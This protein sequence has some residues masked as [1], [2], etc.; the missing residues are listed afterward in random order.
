M[1]TTV[2]IVEILLDTGADP[3]ARDWYGDEPL[4]DVAWSD[5]P[6]V[7][8]AL[9]EAGADLEAR[10]EKD[11][12]PLHVAAGYSDIPAIVTALL[13]AGADLE[14]RDERGWT[15][16]H[17]AAAYNEVPSVVETL[18]HA[19]AGVEAKSYEGATPLLVAA[20]KSATPDVITTLLN[21]GANPTARTSYGITPWVFAQNNEALQGTEVLDWLDPDA[22]GPLHGSIWFSQDDDGAYAWGIAWSFDSSAGAQSEA[23]GQCREYGGTRCAEAG[24]FQEACGALAIGDDNGYGT[25]WGATETEAK[26]DALAQCRVSND[27]CRIEVARCAQSEEAGGKGRRQEEDTAAARAPEEVK[28]AAVVPAPKCDDGVYEYCWREF[29]NKPG[30]YF[31]DE[32]LFHGEYSFH[33]VVHNWSGMCSGGFASGPGELAWARTDGNGAS[34]TE[35]GSFL[36]GKKDGQWINH[37]PGLG[38]GTTVEEYYVDGMRHGQWFWRGA[39]GLSVES[40]YVNGEKVQTTECLDGECYSY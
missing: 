19:G 2:E 22:A 13:K 26:R 3:R 28:P 12:T 39:D 5:D 6:G 30:C 14:A 7:I 40:T 29:S 37:H 18:L 27:D 10:N 38:Q 23:L 20:L 8:K 16:L 1:L 31:R 17:W 24:W 34:W 21:S 36:D 11:V 4:H 15:P 35:S 33:G 32:Y 9:V 25:G